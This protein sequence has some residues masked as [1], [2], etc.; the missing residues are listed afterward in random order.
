MGEARNRNPMTRLEADT[1]LPVQFY[2]RSASLTPQLK[3]R[4]AVL[5]EAFHCVNL[6][7][8]ISGTQNRSAAE[9]RRYTARDE[10]VAWFASDDRD[11]PYSFVNICEALDLDPE[12]VRARI[13]HVVAPFYLEANGDSQKRAVVI[14]RKERA[15]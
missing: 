4:A 5:E 10:T 11:W 7:V 2:A 14:Q 12:A 15:A 9:R 3:L 13:G 8:S 1:I 6:K